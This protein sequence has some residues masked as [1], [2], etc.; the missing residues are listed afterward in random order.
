MS[1]FIDKLNRL[2]RAEPQP[3]GFRMTQAAPPT[4]KIQLVATLA[5][6]S[7]ESLADYV[8]GA[9]AGLL[10]ISSKTSSGAKSLQKISQLMPDIPWGGWLIG[11]GLGR[12]KQITGAG[13]D[14]VVF[15]A[16]DTPLAILQNDEVGKILE[17]EAS[18][19]EGLLRAVNELPVDAVLIAGEQREGHFLTWQ[20]LML[21]QRFADLLT[22][23]L[24]VSVPS[25]VTAGELQALWEAGA[26]SVVV[27]VTAGQPQDRLKE[28]RQLID[29]LAFP[30]PRR[31]QKVEPLLPRTGRDTNVVSVEEEEE[32]ED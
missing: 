19:G 3:I 31:R 17:V 8:A 11:S 28:L 5:Q 15:P 30:S 1:R 32:E 22:K 9:D 16:G 18:L 26:D 23:P 20:H 7:V 4:P 27:E 25:N 24:L 12:I 2:S 10:R 13:C 6:E 29:K 21:F 14:F